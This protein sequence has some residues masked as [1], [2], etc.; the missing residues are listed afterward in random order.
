MLKKLWLIAASGWTLSIAVLCLVSFT[1]LPTVS[2]SDIDKYV[3]ATFHFIFTLLWYLYLRT[4]DRSV[5]NAQILFKIVAFSLVFGIAIELA[6]SL[7]T[8]TRQADIKDVAANL[9]GALLAA[10]CLFVYRKW[11]NKHSNSD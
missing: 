1:D 8:K 11:I 10:V 4:E 9:T 6:Q 5:G 2:V 3:H 7:F